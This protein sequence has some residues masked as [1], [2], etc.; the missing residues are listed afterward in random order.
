MTALV[1]GLVLTLPG[2]PP[3]PVLVVPPPPPVVVVPVALTVE[4]FSRAFTPIPGKH[5][6]WLI[7][8]RTCQ[9]VHVCFTL[10]AGKLRH[11]DVGRRVVEFDFGRCGV[12][13]IFRLN[14]TADVK[15]R[16]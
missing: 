16:G 7:H 2:Q 12:E 11:V 15:Y 13:I 14:G 8:P 5:D 4:Q 1:L 9:P 6:V 10:P 3:P